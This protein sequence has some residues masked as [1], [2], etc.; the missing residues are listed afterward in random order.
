M[1]LGI[2]ALTLFNELGVGCGHDSE[3]LPV[4]PPSSHALLLYPDPCL[5]GTP[6]FLPRPR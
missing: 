2:A 3:A 6:F 5:A 1:K 4:S